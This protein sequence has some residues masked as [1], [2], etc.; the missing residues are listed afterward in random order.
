MSQIQPTMVCLPRE[1]AS[2]VSFVLVHS[3]FA[4]EQQLLWHLWH[5][6]SSCWGRLGHNL[7]LILLTRISLGWLQPPCQQHQHPCGRVLPFPHCFYRTDV[8]PRGPEESKLSCCM[9]WEERG[10]GSH[11][12]FGGTEP[13]RGSWQW[14]GTGRTPAPGACLSMC[15]CSSGSG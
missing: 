9:G 11:W 5:I 12:V 14:F 6:S 2:K 4:A 15:C 8:E 3:S 10:V 7:S 1:P 13:S